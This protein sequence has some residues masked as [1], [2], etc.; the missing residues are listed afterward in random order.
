MNIFTPQT[1]MKLANQ[2]LIP[3]EN[4]HIVFKMQQDNSKPL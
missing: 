1:V 2:E 4:V 3:G